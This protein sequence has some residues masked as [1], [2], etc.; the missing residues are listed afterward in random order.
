MHDTLASGRF[1]RTLNVIDDFNFEVPSISVD[2]S[3][4]GKGYKIVKNIVRLEN[5]A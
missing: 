2:T 5:E 4:P 1:F 3:L